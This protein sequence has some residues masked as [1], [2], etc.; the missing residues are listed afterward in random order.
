MV[1]STIAATIWQ[2]FGSSAPSCSP[3]AQCWSQQSP[4]ASVSYGFILLRCAAR[5]DLALEG[6]ARSGFVSGRAVSECLLR[7]LSV[8]DQTS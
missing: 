7:Y 6:L 8:G 3:S 1:C 2:H 4:E 5:D